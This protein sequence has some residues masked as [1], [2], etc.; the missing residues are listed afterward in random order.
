MKN[1]LSKHN[2]L[3]TAAFIFFNLKIWTLKKYHPDGLVDVRRPPRKPL[4]NWGT[5]SSPLVAEEPWQLRALVGAHLSPGIT[6][7]Q[8]RYSQSQPFRRADPELACTQSQ[9]LWRME[10]LHSP[11]GFRLG[12]CDINSSSSSLPSEVTPPNLHLRQSVSPEGIQVKTNE[13]F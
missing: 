2:Y 8:P 9:S 12:C 4:W 6:L 5:H 3:L 10:E 1:H 13:N 7:S 11:D